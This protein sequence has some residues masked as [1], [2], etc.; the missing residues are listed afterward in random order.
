MNK[1]EQNQDRAKQAF[2]A[3]A[4]ELRA[5]VTAPKQK[6]MA[7][8]FAIED[9]P[10]PPWIGEIVRR[11]EFER[12]W[13]EAGRAARAEQKACTKRDRTVES[14]ETRLHKNFNRQSGINH[15][16]GR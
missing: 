3:S 4:N 8:R 9:G 10:R 6:P 16:I 11:Q 13:Q 7:P 5:E 15:G 2:G 1:L 12:R 14:K